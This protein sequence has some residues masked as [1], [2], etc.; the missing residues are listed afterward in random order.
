MTP[1]PPWSEGDSHL[2]SRAIYRNYSESRTNI[3]CNW[4]LLKTDHV[5]DA[6]EK[7]QPSPSP[8]TQPTLKLAPVAAFTYVTGAWLCW[9]VAVVCRCGW[10]IQTQVWGVQIRLPPGRHWSFLRR[11]RVGCSPR[12][13]MVETIPST[14]PDLTVLHDIKEL[15]SYWSRNVYLYIAELNECGGLRGG[16]SSSR[17]L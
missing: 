14:P 8:S 7:R 9:S 15:N 16:H 12:L 5:L 6:N 2:G 4:T 1:H 17:S 11:Y 13:M 3:R 10:I